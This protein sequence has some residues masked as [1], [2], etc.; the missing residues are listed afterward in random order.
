M[1]ALSLPR[2]DS[3]L[4]ALA[5]V[6]IALAIILNR[7]DVVHALDRLKRRRV[8][9]GSDCSQALRELIAHHRAAALHG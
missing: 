7:N 4:Q 3:P 6:L 1:F 9:K 5:V 2:L 8:G